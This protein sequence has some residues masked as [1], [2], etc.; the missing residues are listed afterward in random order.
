MTFDIRS[1]VRMDDLIQDTIQG[2]EMSACAAPHSLGQRNVFGRAGRPDGQ[3]SSF[4]Q[5]L[6]HTNFLPVGLARRRTLKNVTLSS[7]FRPKPD[8]NSTQRLTG[9]HSVSRR[10]LSAIYLAC[11]DRST[12]ASTTIRTAPCDERFNGPSLKVYLIQRTSRYPENMFTDLP[13]TH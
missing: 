6:G 12:Y 2:I 13:V 10:W 7:R 1:T 4:G 11:H 5:R 9:S 3:T 8:P